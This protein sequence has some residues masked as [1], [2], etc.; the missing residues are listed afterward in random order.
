MAISRKYGRSLV[1]PGIS[2]LGVYYLWSQ[3]KPQQ[4]IRYSFNL[5]S[6]LQSQISFLKIRYIKNIHNSY[7]TKILIPF[8]G[9]DSFTPISVTIGKK[10]PIKKQ[11]ILKSKIEAMLPHVKI[12]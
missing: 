6:L 1:I 3:Y 8:N 2:R 5:L 9:V 11:T 7:P 12:Y 4:E 10:M